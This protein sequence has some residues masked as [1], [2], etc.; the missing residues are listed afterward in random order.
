MDYRANKRILN[1]GITND[2][3][4]LK[5]ILNICSHQEIANQ[6]YP[7]ILLYTN[8]NGED[9]NSNDSSCW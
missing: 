1:R 5:E 6:N 2:C 4:S 7:E 9:K 8:Q 3:E